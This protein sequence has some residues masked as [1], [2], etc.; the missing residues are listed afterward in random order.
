MKRSW[1]L[2]WAAAGV[3][4]V[5]QAISEA[6]TQVRTAALGMVLSLTQVAES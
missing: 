5:A 4:T 3:A 1:S 2:R 6:M